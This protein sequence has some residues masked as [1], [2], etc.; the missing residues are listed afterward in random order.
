M[1]VSLKHSKVTLHY[2]DTSLSD[3]SSSSDDITNSMNAELEVRKT[4]C[5]GIRIAM[6]R[7][8]RRKEVEYALG[9]LD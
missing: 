6:N 5:M 4:S 2:D 7:Y 3:I 8:Q 9:L 1:P